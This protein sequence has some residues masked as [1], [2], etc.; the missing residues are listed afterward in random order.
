MPFRAI[1]PHGASRNGPVSAAGGAS[2]A[3]T[4]F[5]KN[6][7]MP[8]PAG[9]QPVVTDAVAAEAL[10]PDVLQV[11]FLYTSCSVKSSIAPQR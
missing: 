11:N 2:V 3:E 6:E 4:R 9:W 1:R 8:F 5:R 7:S 10:R